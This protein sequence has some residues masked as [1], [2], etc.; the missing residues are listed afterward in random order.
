MIVLSKFKLS[1]R[2][3][4]VR[5]C[6]VVKMQLLACSLVRIGRPVCLP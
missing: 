5:D 4:D 2:V 6:S 3:A 1:R